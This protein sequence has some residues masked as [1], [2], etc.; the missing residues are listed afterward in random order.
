MKLLASGAARASWQVSQGHVWQVN[1]CGAGSTLGF[2]RPSQA[3]PP[4]S[5]SGA[6]GRRTGRG[7]SLLQAPE[8][9]LC[10]R[11]GPSEGCRGYL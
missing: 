4:T 1:L 8:L 9:N 10:F 6:T 7:Q 11:Q 3:T 2:V 5:A